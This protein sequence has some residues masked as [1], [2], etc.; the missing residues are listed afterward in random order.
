VSKETNYAE[1]YSKTVMWKGV[2]GAKINENKFCYIRTGDRAFITMLRKSPNVKEVGEYYRS[3]RA[4]NIAVQF[5]V[6]FSAVKR[7][8]KLVKSKGGKLL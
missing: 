3:G 5:L 1:E 6:E 8:E 2:D 4:Y 7:L